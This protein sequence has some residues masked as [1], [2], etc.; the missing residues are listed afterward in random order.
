MALIT[1]GKPIRAATDNRQNKNTTWCNTSIRAFSY[2]KPVSDSIAKCNKAVKDDRTGAPNAITGIHL[3]SLA[4]V[5][6][7]QTPPNQ[8][9]NHSAVKNP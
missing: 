4:T 3:R 9:Y 6:C 2:P 7:P 8:F 5:E 1:P